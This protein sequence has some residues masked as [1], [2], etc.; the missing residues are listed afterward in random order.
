MVSFA[1]IQ[2]ILTWARSTK[3][4]VTIE[5]ENYP[6]KVLIYKY[7]RAIDNQGQIVEW[8]RA[9]G[10]QPPHKV[11]T[12]MKIKKIMV[13]SLSKETKELRSLNQLLQEAGG[14]AG[15]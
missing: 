2:R 6:Y 13:Q 11:L 15:I 5:F 7:I 8:H 14:P 1:Q 3:H 4:K 12:S 10:P 9:F